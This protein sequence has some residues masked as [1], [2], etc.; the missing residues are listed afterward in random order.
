[1]KHILLALIIIP[2][3]NYAQWTQLTTNTSKDLYAISFSSGNIGIATG[4]KGMI[5][6][7]TDG[8]N[9][10]S[11]S[12]ATS[13]NLNA[14]AFGHP[15]TVFVGGDATTNNTTVLKSNDAGAVWTLESANPKR[16][17]NDLFFISAQ[18]GFM[19][20]SY[21]SSVSTVCFSAGSCKMFINK[22]SDGGVTWQSIDATG[23]NA[24][25]NIKS[26]AIWFVNDS[27]GYAVSQNSRVVK[28][29]KSGS[30]WTDIGDSTISI[31][32]TNSIY[33]DVHFIDVNF[34]YVVGR[35]KTTS[36]GIILKTTDGG[37]TWDSSVVSNILYG[38]WTI[39]AN[40]A[41]AVGASGSIYKTIDGGSNWTIETPVGTNLKKVTFINDS[42]GYAVGDGGVILKTSVSIV[43]PPFNVAFNTSP[44][45]TVCEG[46]TINFTNTSSGT[47]SREWFIDDVSSGTTINFSNQFNT[48]GSFEVKLKAD[49]AGVK[50]DSAMV[51]ITVIAKPVASFSVS[52]DTIDQGGTVDFTNTSTNATN[53]S[54]QIDDVEFETT[55]NANYQFPNTGNFV[56]KLIASNGS[57]CSDSTV[58][59]SIYVKDTTG[60]GGGTGI[61][62]NLLS[63][64][65]VYPNPNHGNFNISFNVK[66]QVS[67]NVDLIDILGKSI[68]SERYVNYIGS[69]SKEI[70]LNDTDGIYFLK[71]Q[72][73]N[74]IVYK[75]IIGTN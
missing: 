74:D 59:Q 2:M 21:N 8:I 56:I 10:D 32:G 51:T 20:A 50:F 35:Y 47:S 75:K 7:T 37:L 55:T 39:D 36:S 4:V 69:Y 16:I 23:V 29:T 49:S 60:N 18:E 31:A 61:K 44:N 62:D 43:V 6:R 71:L 40:N 34:G 15:D 38:V 28:T 24:T 22:T 33:Y 52:A 68:Y 53:Y 45:D 19:A 14:V 42:L 64:L 58:T 54:W 5:L 11:I 25:G 63:S 26:N 67:L 46:T 72:V 70:N 41:Y 27:T 17:V 57:I 48:A 3:F 30:P 13:E 1:M 65:V 12:S 9:W 66:N 73:G